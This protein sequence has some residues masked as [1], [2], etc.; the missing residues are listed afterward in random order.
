MKSG[1]TKVSSFPVSLNFRRFQA[2]SAESEPFSVKVS[3]FE[4]VALE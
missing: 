1:V 3:H 4:V 2:M